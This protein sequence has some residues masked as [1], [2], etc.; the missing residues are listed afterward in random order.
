MKYGV[1]SYPGSINMGDEVQSIAAMRLLP[2]V[3]YLV[4]RDNIHKKVTDE[5]IKLVCNGWFAEKPLNWPPADNILPLFISMHV[6]R[7]NQS[8][9]LLL[10]DNLTDYY[11]RFG[12]IG[13]RDLG[14]LKLLKKNGIEAW[15]SGDLTLT[16]ENR[17][18]E[19]NNDIL[20]VDPLRYNYTRKYRDF[21]I[22]QIVPKKY[23]DAV[24]IITQRRTNLNASVQDR[25]IDA[26]NLIELYSKAKVVITSRIHCALPCLALGTPVYFIN[27]GYHST[28]FNLND[29]FEGL[30]ELFRVIEE[31]VLPFGSKSIKDF[32]A[33]F[34][35]LYRGSKIKPLPIDWDNPDPNPFH[36]KDLATIQRERVKDFINKT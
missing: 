20:L 35:N 28:Y 8:Y 10:R 36:F 9:K 6:T 5:V 1:I 17:Y 32:G 26:E 4:D 25:F 34:F 14:T 16:L 33:R 31:N 19:R 11:N 18:S 7:S 30:L 15:F 24:K 3:D 2:R 22:N 12:P 21:V 29:R 27:A 13:C 23:R